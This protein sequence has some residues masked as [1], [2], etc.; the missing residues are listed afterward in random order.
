MP[1]LLVV[2][3]A[4][5]CAIL[6]LHDWV[7]LGALNDVRAVREADSTSRLIRVTLIQ[8]VPYT[9]GL[10]YSA[11]SLGGHM[12]GWLWYWLWISY[13]LLFAGE[14][15]GWWVPYL[16]RPEPERAARYQSMFGRTHSFLPPRNGLV[17]NTL[18][19]V[20][21]ICTASTLVVLGVMS[22]A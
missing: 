13:G 16:F 7:P 20:L 19:T 4:I 6:W 8:S 2:L 22:L 3:Q 1:I 12:P 10:W 11:R 21:H 17:P 18:H 15:R 9:I 5:Q 14:L